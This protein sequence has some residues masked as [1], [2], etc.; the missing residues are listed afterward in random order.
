MSDAMPKPEEYW[1]AFIVDRRERPMVAYT[2]SMKPTKEEAI[3]RARENTQAGVDKGVPGVPPV[4]SPIVAA[5]MLQNPKSFW[6]DVACELADLDILGADAVDAMEAM[7][8]SFAYTTTR[9]LAM[10]AG[11]REEANA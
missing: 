8:R 6:S 5:N 4:D 2:A 10:E 3:Q 9:V 1:V 7:Q 11:R